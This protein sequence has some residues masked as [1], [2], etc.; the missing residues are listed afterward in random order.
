MTLAEAGQRVQIIKKTPKVAGKLEFGT[1]RCQRRLAGGTAGRITRC[2]G[3]RQV[4]I[5][6]IERC[7]KERLENGWKARLQALV[8]SYGESLVNN[9]ELLGSIRQNTLRTL[10]RCA[11]NARAGQ[12]TISR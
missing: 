3:C 1:G 4:M 7:F 8:P 6:V 2:F 9:A 5:E 11:I 12:L 10:A